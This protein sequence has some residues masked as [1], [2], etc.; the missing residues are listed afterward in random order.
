MKT[1]ILGVTL[2]LS[3]GL[4]GEAL[5]DAKAA[6]DKARTLC[7]GCHG[8]NGRSVNPV[9]PH[10][11]GQQAAYLAKTLQDYKSGARQ[12]LNMAAMVSGL[13]DQEIEDLAAY[14]A[15][16]PPGG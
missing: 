4:A 11:A 8:P 13:T 6:A 5:A 16:L 9:W 7:A 3:L 14:Y 2:L 10:L 1:S 12:D 15:A